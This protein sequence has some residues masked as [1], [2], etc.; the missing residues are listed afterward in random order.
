MIL[1]GSKKHG[2][3][4][5]GM[6]F[7]K[8]KEFVYWLDPRVKPE[9]DMCC[10]LKS[11][12]PSDISFNKGNLLEDLFLLA[13][14]RTPQ[15]GFSFARAKFTSSESG[16]TYSISCAPSC[17]PR[18]WL[19]DPVQDYDPSKIFPPRFPPAREWHIF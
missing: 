14:F 16:M 6:F 7:R 18:A 9:D 5:G 10:F 12:C 4:K 11:L 17:H 8:K 13:G 3:S 19:G 2:G 15:S 1:F